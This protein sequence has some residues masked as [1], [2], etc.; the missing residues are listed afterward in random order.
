MCRIMVRTYRR[1]LKL[2][3][4]LASSFLWV[5]SRVYAQAPVSLDKTVSEHIFHSDEIF[6]YEDP[7]AKLTFNEV[8]KREQQFVANKKHYP[9]NPD[10][11]SAYWFRVKVTGSS[12]SRNF[13][14]EFYDQTT[15][16][17]TAYLPDSTGHYIKSEAGE[18]F[19]FRDRLFQ[20]K[21][22]EFNVPAVPRGTYY[23]YF[24]VKSS[25]DISV[26]IVLR[27]LSRFVQYGLNE[28]FSFGLFYGMILIFSL[29]NLLMFFAVRRRQYLYYVFYILSIG[30]YEMASDGIGFQYLWHDYPLLNSYVYGI[31]L[32]LMSIFALVFTS[33]LLHVKAKAPFFYRIINIAMAA[34]TLFFLFCLLVRPDWFIYKF[35]EF[36][37]LSIV[38]FT[39]IWIWRNGYKPARFLV[40][41]YSVLYVG[42][43]IKLITALGFARYIPGYLTYYSLSFCFVAEMVFLSFAIGDQVRLLKKRKERAQK[44]IMEQ[45]QLNVALKDNINKELESKVRDRTSELE[46][47]ASI[48][49]QKSKIIEEQNEELMSKNQLLEFQTQEISRMNKLLELDNVELKTNIEK[50]TDA[51]VLSSDMDFEEFSLKYPDKEAC[52]KFLSD[53]KWEQDYKCVKCA[54]TFYFTGHVPYSRRCTKCGYEESVLHQTIFENNRI[55]INKAF[56]LVYLLYTNKGNISSHNLSKKLGIRQSTC[57]TYASRVN[58]ILKSRKKSQKSSEK[59]GWSKLVLI[60]K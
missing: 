51:R 15:E 41:G 55:P 57:W 17:I 14:I 34:R 8:L 7:S 21:N 6:I 43:L 9:K 36:V 29:H 47:K 16:N 13:L 3:I 18:L 12:A 33:E 38:F 53:I 44:R 24:R 40:M 35:V 50:V 45:M 22:F 20:H 25:R 2:F 1:M 54:N 30:L 42:F 39:G 27:T 56:Y 5:S 58:K 28:Y 59:S 32:F 4:V 60:Q 37:P 49:L 52:Y 23:Y 26:I 19:N 46:E 48:I 10:K 11:N 31:A